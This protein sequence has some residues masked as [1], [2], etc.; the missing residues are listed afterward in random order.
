MIVG[1]ASALIS[2]RAAVHVKNLQYKEGSVH[3]HARRTY[4]RYIR[5]IL[6]LAILAFESYP[7]GLRS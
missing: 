5:Y 6:N 7:I 4:F 3:R 2:G 1:V